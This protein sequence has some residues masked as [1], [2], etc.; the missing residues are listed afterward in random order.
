[1]ISH[2]ACASVLT[3]H[4]L[5]Y[6]FSPLKINN[7]VQLRTASMY[8]YGQI[9]MVANAP[10]K[11]VVSLFMAGAEPLTEEGSPPHCEARKSSK[12]RDGA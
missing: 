5:A 3:T 7:S 4:R 2:E 12:A 6:L 1:M 10:A 9:H 8:L 11:I